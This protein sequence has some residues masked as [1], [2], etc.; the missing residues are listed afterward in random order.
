M[1]P[2]QVPYNIIIPGIWNHHIGNDTGSDV[3]HAL[4]DPSALRALQLMRFCYASRRC[5]KLLGKVHMKP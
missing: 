1:G 4:V 2:L 3:M 5:K